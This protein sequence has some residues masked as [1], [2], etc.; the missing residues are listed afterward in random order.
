M[1]W[2]KMITADPIC[3]EPVRLWYLRRDEQGRKLCAGC[4]T[5]KPEGAFNRYRRRADGLRA[6]CRGCPATPFCKAVGCAKRWHDTAS[7]NRPYCRMHLDRLQR[8]GD[9][10]VTASQLRGPYRKSGSDVTYGQAH[11]RASALW[12]PAKRH[13]CVTCGN[14]A[15]Q[16]AYDGTDPTQLLDL[17]R[18]KGSAYFYSEWPEF[19][20]PM[21]TKCHRA[22]DS[23]SMQAELREYR[24]WRHRTGRTLANETGETL[25]TR[26][27][28]D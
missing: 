24:I 2:G 7:V 9:A 3:D 26:S 23:A 6:N 12:G 1:F 15:A 28:Q 18:V 14:L 21:C 20:M 22:R 4:G 13:P 5:W 10:Y 11:R 27:N 25:A 19:Y 17:A 16:W 8:T